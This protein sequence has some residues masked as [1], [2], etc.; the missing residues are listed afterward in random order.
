[1][2][3][4][5]KIIF[6]FFLSL[7]VSLQLV[8]Q[9]KFPQSLGYDSLMSL[10]KQHNKPMFL[11]IHQRDELFAP[12][13]VSISQKTKDVLNEQFVSGIVQLDPNDFNHPLRKT[14]NLPTPI[15]LFT[16]NN[17]FPLLR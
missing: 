12:F 13:R 3:P 15:Y 8:A 11:V 9:S 4:Y 10:A 16:D 17:G 14:Y 2:Q 1:D 7:F 6:L 5:I